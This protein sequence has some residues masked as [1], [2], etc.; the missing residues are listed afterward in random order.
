MPSRRRFLAGGATL[1]GAVMLGGCTSIDAPVDG[2]AGPVAGEV[3][4]T[5]SV[6]V[7]LLLPLSATGNAGQLA[8]DMRNSADLALR[9][10]PNSNIQVLIKDDRGTPDGARAAATAAITEGAKLILG[11]VFAQAVAA[12][13]SVAKPAAVPVIAFSTDSTVAQKGVYLMSFLPQSD[14]DRIIS[15]SAS[16]GKRSYAVLL[17]SNAYGTVVEATLQRAVGNAGGR[18]VVLERYNL[19]RTSMQEKATAVAAVVKQGTVNAIFIPDGGDAAPFLAQILAAN[20][21]HPASVRYLGS[22]QW[23]DPRVINESNLSGGWFPGPDLTGFQA[24]AV[25][26]KAAYG[27]D[28]VRNA[29]L[30]YDGVSLAIGLT[31]RFGDS[32]FSEKVLTNPS[33]FVGVDGVFRFTVNGVSQRA[34]AVYQ[35]ERATL[36]VISPAPKNFTGAGF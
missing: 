31:G 34:L 20:G 21:V 12:T 2:Q 18:I 30:A 6:R 8:K 35:I 7:A 22:G 14:V 3:L 28:P 23:N 15:F 32:A 17:P 1:C 27:N 36:G 10:F 13:A 33:G 25:R 11:P 19:D 29:S 5:G 4:G 9:E 26:F 24:Y 16:Q